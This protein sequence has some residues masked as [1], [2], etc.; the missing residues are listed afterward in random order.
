MTVLPDHWGAAHRINARSFQMVPTV[1]WNRSGLGSA[2]LDGTVTSVA[3]RD[4]GSCFICDW[5]TA[6]GRRPAS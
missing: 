2:R 6:F 5:I 1:D 4:Q 3:I